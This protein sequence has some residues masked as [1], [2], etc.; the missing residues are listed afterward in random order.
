M[1][2]KLLAMA[3]CIGLAVASCDD[4]TDSIGSSLIERTD[5]LAISTGV[6]DVATRSIVADSVYSRN[7]IGYLGKVKDPETGAY[8]TSDYITQFHCLD[9]FNLP[10]QDSIVSRQDGLIIADS[11][12]IR[13]FYDNLFGD[14]LAVMKL[15]ANEMDK[16]LEENKKYYSNFN[17]ETE[18]FTRTDGIHKAHVYTIANKG[19]SDADRK[20]A[21]YGRN[22]R[23]PLNEPYTDKEGNTYNNYGTYVLRKCLANP[24]N[25]KNAYNFI[26]NVCP[27]FYIKSESGVGGMAY[28]SFSQLNIF[29]RVKYNGNTS[30]TMLKFTGTEE[31]VQA[32]RI[33]NDKATIKQL[34]DDP[35]CTYIK[36]PAGI[37]TEMT[38]PVDDIIKNHANDTL[39]TAK[40]VLTRLSN[41]ND[42]DFE[43]DVPNTLLMIP[44]DSLYS[45]FEKGNLPNNR[46]SFI[47]SRDY[48]GSTTAT[49]QYRNTYTFSNISNLIRAMAEARDDGGAGY[50]ALHPNWNKVVLVPVSTVY[51]T[52]ASGS[53]TTQ[54]LT[55]VAH[56][57]SLASTR[58][59]GGTGNTDKIQISIVY[60]KFDSK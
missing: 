12:E 45:F 35:S 50:E 54:V 33:T 11:C 58:L 19:D 10:E 14:S 42:S 29:M 41:N 57:M 28:I 21:D 7:A 59:V 39:S 44:A 5:K 24:E 1:K 9:D 49:R 26:H 18:G 56:N 38:L 36:S 6:F 20:S 51:S 52:Q 46:T 32:T 40:V 37:F 60:T 4:T 30:K 25:L 53:S 17:P 55:K 8:I 23:I 22:I 16:P 48:T 2:L 34:A 31:V 43:L 13:L 15:S 47:T 27:G 3:A